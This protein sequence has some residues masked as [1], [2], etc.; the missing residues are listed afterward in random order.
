ML[1]EPDR[2]ELENEKNFVIISFIINISK[3]KSYIEITNLK[4][5]NELSR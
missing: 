5:S 2:R 4:S 3:H 1:H